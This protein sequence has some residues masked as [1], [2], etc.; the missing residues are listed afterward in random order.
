MVAAR[1][2]SLHL[3]TTSAGGLGRHGGR[4]WLTSG[5]LKWRNTLGVGNEANNAAAIG[6]LYGHD[7]TLSVVVAVGTNPPLT[8]SLTAPADGSSGPARPAYTLAI[9]AT[10]G[11]IV[12]N[13]SMPVWHGP[14]AGDSLLHVCL[15]DSSANAA[16]GG[17]GVVYVPHEDGRRVA[18]PTSLP[19]ELPH[20]ALPRAHLP[21]PRFQRAHKPDLT[22]A[23]YPHDS[24]CP[25]EP[26]GTRMRPPR[27][28]HWRPK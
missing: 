4:Y 6:R 19:V 18:D 21:H 15:P 28:P 24:H 10:N 9:D 23:R 8:T 7:S 25:A 17:D 5:S 16:I 3:L 11:E 12:W 20:A 2:S 14:A 13:Y 27:D 26:Q 22:R 1:R